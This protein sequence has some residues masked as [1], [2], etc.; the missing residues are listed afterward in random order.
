[1]INKKIYK[2]IEA[3]WIGKLEPDS[4]DDEVLGNYERMKKSDLRYK[5]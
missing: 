5:N 2:K 3:T 4:E 1:L